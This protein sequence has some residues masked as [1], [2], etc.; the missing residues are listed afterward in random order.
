MGAGSGRIEVAGATAEQSE[1]LVEAP[2]DRVVLLARAEV[3]LPHQTGGVAGRA[4]HVADRRLASREPEFGV[5]VP[6]V[7]RGWVVLVAEPVL[8]A[9]GVETGPHRAADRRRG[10]AVGQPDAVR[11]QFVDVRGRD[12]RRSVGPDVAVAE[13]VGE[14]DD[15]VGRRR[16][17]GRVLGAVAAWT[18]AGQG[19]AQSER[20]RSSDPL[21]RLHLPLLPWSSVWT[22]AVSVAWG[23][24]ECYRLS[25]ETGSGRDSVDRQGTPGMPR[26]SRRV[27]S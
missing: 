24:L 7:V 17:R 18:A 6:F 23:R 13:V 3:P 27:V 12:D 10:V 22:G 15:H 5:G 1:E 9:A 21:M 19:H 11:R 14:D 26:R 4:H 2:F 20:R 8:V 25:T 16:G